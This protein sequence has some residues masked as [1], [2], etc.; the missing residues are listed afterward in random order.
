MDQRSLKSDSTNDDLVEI[1]LQYERDFS[2]RIAF[3]NFDPLP[4]Y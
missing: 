2:A 4:K 3:N 1:H